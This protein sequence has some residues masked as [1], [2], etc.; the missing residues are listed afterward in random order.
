MRIDNISFRSKNYDI[1]K[2][3]TYNF[4][5]GSGTAIIGPSGSGKSMLLKILA[6]KIRPSEG[7]ILLSPSV[8]LFPT[9]GPYTP[10]QTIKD[11]CFSHLHTMKTK[12]KNETAILKKSISTMVEMIGLSPFMDHP[13]GMVSDCSYK[14]SLIISQVAQGAQLLIFDNP[15][16]SMDP[17]SIK[18]LAKLFRYLKTTLGKTI[19][20]ASHNFNFLFS[21]C[22]NYLALLNG[23]NFSEGK[24][25][26]ITAK[27]VE[28]LY[29]I[30]IRFQKN[31]ESANP[32]ILFTI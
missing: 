23:E 20:I 15:D 28:K 17:L 1:I 25:T 26:E 8:S 29:G 30:K 27:T 22:D 21:V 9:E 7:E 10:E 31:I 32:E 11:I 4:A 14:K 16:N 19:I 13:C 3:I 5:P 24:I 18:E 12:N 2:N 6:E